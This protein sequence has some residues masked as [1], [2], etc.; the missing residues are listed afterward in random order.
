[1]GIGLGIGINRSNYAQGIFNAYQSRVIADGGVTE[2][3]A[4]VDAV[5]SLLQSASLLLIPSGYKSG[6]AYAEIPTNG[7]G[8]LTWTRASTALRTNSSGLLESMGSGVPRLSYMY[9]SCPALLLEPQRTN[10]ALYSEQFDN[11]SWGK[12]FCS[13]TAN[14]TTSPDGNTTADTFTADGSNNQ[15]YVVGS[16]SGTVTSGSSCTY[17]MYAKKNTNNFIQLWISNTFGGMFANFD[18]NNGVVGTLGVG[19]GGSNPT[20]SITSVGNGWYRCSMTFVPT[21]TGVVGSLVAMTSSASAVRAEANT[22]STSVFLWGAQVEAG[23]YP[24]TYIP[25]TTASA[26]RIADTATKTGI[27]SLI[28]Q[29][30]GV[31]FVDFYVNGIGANNINIYNNDRSPSTISTNA[32]LYKPNGSIEC[33]TFLGNGTFNTISISAS[34]YTIGQRIKLAYRYKSGDFAVY[35]N[36]IQKATSTSTMTFVGTK[37]QIYLDDNAVIYGYQESVHYNQFALFTTALTNAELVSLT[38]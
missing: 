29:T 2:G 8:D 12:I 17:T 19:S 4:C 5:S 6:K 13:V 37:S 7:N 10:L 24:T 15:H 33:Q 36:G 27:S 28:G 1:M 22:L 32:I 11:V 16:T 38:T 30:E 21:S 20:S 25:T 31:I 35:I 23:A 14:S 26:T 3:G 34:T 9:G 18:L